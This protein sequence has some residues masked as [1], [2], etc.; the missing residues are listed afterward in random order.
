MPSI[1]CPGS[2]KMRRS[3]R[4]SSLPNKDIL[5]AIELGDPTSGC[6]DSFIVASTSQRP[7]VLSSSSDES[8]CSRR[9]GQGQISLS[10]SFQVAY[11]Y[12]G[13]APCKPISN[14]GLPGIK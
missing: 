13:D 3:N 11:K 9:L 8:R 10:Q 14:E 7:V 1:P 5:L 2:I 6:S 4:T 12:P